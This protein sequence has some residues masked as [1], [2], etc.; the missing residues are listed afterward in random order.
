MPPIDDDV[1]HPGL[2]AP[3]EVRESYLANGS[4]AIDDLGGLGVRFWQSPTVVDHHPKVPCASLAAARW[5]R[6]HS[7][8][9]DWAGGGLTFGHG[10]ARHAAG[11]GDLAA[12]LDTAHL[13]T[14]R[15][16][17]ARTD[18]AH[19]DTARTDT[20]HRDTAHRETAHPDTAHPDT[21]HTDTAGPNCPVEIS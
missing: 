19:C 18:T 20:A 4:A 8:G 6:R 21:A 13:D 12:H 1:T 5:S 2:K 16:D 3:G 15:T 11:S 9:A 17:T 7:T 14:A 10:A